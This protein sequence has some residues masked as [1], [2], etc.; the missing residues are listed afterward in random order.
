MLCSND[1][2]VYLGIFEGLLKFSAFKLNSLKQIFVGRM[3][4][5]LVAVANR[6]WD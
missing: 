4:L 3:H 6:Y 5:Q 1:H 2:T